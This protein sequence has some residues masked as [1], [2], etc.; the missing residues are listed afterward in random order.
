MNRETIARTITSAIVAINACLVIFG[1]NLFGNITEDIIYQVV[2][3]IVMIVAWAVSHWK[4][5]DFTKEAAEGT[6]YT[7]ML[8]EQKKGVVNG[9]NFFD[10]VEEVE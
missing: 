8:K 2:S 5:N 6:G 3:A 10:G 9:E 7:R 4:N 1:V